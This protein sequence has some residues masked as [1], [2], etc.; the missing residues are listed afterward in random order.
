MNF[1]FVFLSGGHSIAISGIPIYLNNQQRVKPTSKFPQAELSPSEQQIAPA[2]IL[3]LDKLHRAQGEKET[4]VLNE[5]D[6]QKNC[7]ISSAI[8]RVSPVHQLLNVKSRPV[9]FVLSNQFHSV[10]IGYPWFRSNFNKKMDVC[11]V[12]V[13]LCLI[14]PPKKKKKKPCRCRHT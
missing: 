1:G 8:V 2:E 10:L 12:L 6:D 14:P 3:D 11:C 13:Y 9:K 5:C 4:G 7:I